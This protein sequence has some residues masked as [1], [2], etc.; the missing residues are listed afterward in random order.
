MTKAIITVPAY[1]SP[2]QREATERAG[3][4]A[5]LTKVK[6]LREPE[7]A[8]LAYGLIQESNQIVMVVDLGGGTLDVSVLDVGGGYVEVIATSG[9]SF[10][11]GDD[12]DFALREWL[13]SSAIDLWLPM[14]LKTERSSIGSTSKIKQAR[15]ELNVSL[16]RNILAMRQ[17][18]E[19]ACQAKISL[20]SVIETG[21]EIPDLLE[22][23]SLPESV[24]C[25]LL[26]STEYTS[27]S[28][29]YLS[30]CQL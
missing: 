7:A 27:L 25:L 20:S 2:A 18:L 11:G 15:R 3:Y 16:R 23:S 12:F 14:P 1:F 29:P 24:R 26:E 13:I 30:L 10:L 5:G 4:A 22:I 8:A 19:C 6:L 21:C 9:D 17:L 28:S